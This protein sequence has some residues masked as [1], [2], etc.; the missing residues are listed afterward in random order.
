MAERIS[1]TI[2]LIMGITIEGAPPDIEEF[3]CFVFMLANV[4][5]M[6]QSDNDVP[7]ITLYRM[8]SDARHRWWRLYQLFLWT[9]GVSERRCTTG[10]TETWL[11]AVNKTQSNI[12]DSLLV[13]QIL[14]WVFFISNY[15]F[16][17]PD[18]WISSP[19][20]AQ[21]LFHSLTLVCE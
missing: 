9:V 2:S 20:V 8:S 18:A 13:T 10:A 5:L 3:G 17:A 16:F 7:A 1:L 19:E 4:M 15:I 6:W 14:C 21:F 11:Q 12:S